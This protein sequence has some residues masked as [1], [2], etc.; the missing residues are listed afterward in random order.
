MELAPRMTMMM[1]MIMMIVILIS[2]CMVV[3]GGDVEMSHHL[4]YIANL[5]KGNEIP[6]TVSVVYKL[7]LTVHFYI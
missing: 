2:E 5:L 6:N 7:F 1:V 4:I 3:C